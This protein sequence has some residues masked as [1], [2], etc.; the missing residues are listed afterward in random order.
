MCGF[1]G[2]TDSSW[3]YE[4]ALAT[5]VHRGPDAGRLVPGAPFTVGF[6][7]L[8][9][10]DLS[11]A[12]NQ[13]MFG[14]DAGSWIVFNGEIY[15]FRDLR[16]ELER[17]GQRFETDSD[18]EVVLR[19]YSA[20]GDTFVDRI[21]GMFAIAIWDAARRQIKLYRDRIGIKPLYYY[22]DGRHFG[23]ASELK[24]ITTACAGRGLEIDGTALYD[25]LTYR[26]V[27]APK[28]PYRRCFKLPPGQT[29]VFE[30]DSGVL[31]GAQR[32]WQVPVP[33][34]PRRVTVDEAAEE[35]RSLMR[36]CVADQMIADV[37]VGFFLSGGVDSS[38]VVAAA[39]E[40]GAPLATFSI[41]FDSHEHSETEF[42][43]EVAQNFGCDHTE[44][45]L[46]RTQARALLPRLREWYD[47]PFVDESSFPTYLVA[48]T[49]RE[50]VKV[51]LT[52]DG[53]DEVFGGYRTYLRFERYSRFPAWPEAVQQALQAMSSRTL[54]RGLRRLL[55]Q[56]DWAGS[57]D[58]ALWAKLMNG[59]TPF[60]ALSYAKR[61]GIGD[62]YD[63]Y[64]H[65]REHWRAELPV[66]TRLQVLDLQTYLPDEVLTKV[67]RTTMAVSL[68]ARVPLLDR[69]IVEFSF[70]LPEAVRYHGGLKGLLR[71]AY[72]GV[73]PAG[74][75]DRKKKG[76]GIPRYYLRDLGPRGTQLRAL[77][78]FMAGVGARGSEGPL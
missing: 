70:A 62:D 33:E 51:V 31:H 42:A 39:A 18:T 21:D 75:M 8:S 67:D 46:T 63:P 64:W 29:L 73:L 30:P 58:L 1:V 10:V 15:G 45:V 36:R 59:M 27:P 5:L 26:Y 47:E 7:R 32:Y 43:R 38:S 72:R 11:A 44:R 53:G 37:P 3:D 40:T 69:R 20:W 77:E 60:E 57:T 76:F 56:L 55:T 16:R 61:L 6:R 54:R 28:T 41:G 66:R 23:F 24:A 34:A 12:A 25:F 52:G 74:A 9:I 65:Y 4:A 13:P 49:A 17:E 71:E 78:P 35:L 48:A 50:K 14:A 2:G 68:E 19:A 22:W